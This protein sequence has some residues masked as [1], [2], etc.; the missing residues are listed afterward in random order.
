[1]RPGQTVC[2]I[3]RPELGIGIFCS[4]NGMRATVNFAKGRRALK[5]D[6]LRLKSLTDAQKAQM[7][8]LDLTLPQYLEG[9]FG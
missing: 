8:C 4:S 7:E 3:K 2:S 1:M 9:L 5:P 6:D